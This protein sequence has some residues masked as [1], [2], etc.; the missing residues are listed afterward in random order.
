MSWRRP[1][2]QTS[3]RPCGRGGANGRGGIDLLRT[4][5]PGVQGAAGGEIRR[6]LDEG[7]EAKGRR[8]ILTGGVCE[9]FLLFA[10]WVPPRK[11]PAWAHYIDHRWP[12]RRAAHRR[13][14]DVVGVECP[15]PRPS[16][17]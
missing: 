1:V 11:G 12:S 16:A 9:R 17:K 8:T 3:S 2:P 14:V 6:R 5:S 10:S 13:R 7:M 4:P 15:Y